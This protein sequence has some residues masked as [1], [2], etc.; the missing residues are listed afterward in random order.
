MIT[1]IILQWGMVSFSLVYIAF[2]YGKRLK[3]VNDKK[4]H[5]YCITIHL[6]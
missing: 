2:I 3:M 5:S 1:V 4:N 6:Q